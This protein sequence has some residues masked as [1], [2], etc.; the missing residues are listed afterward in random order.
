M[1]NDPQEEQVAGLLN[2]SP[3][4]LGDAFDGSN[5]DSANGNN[6]APTESPVMV[7][8]PET[9]QTSTTNDN[10]EEEKYDAGAVAGNGAYN[11][12][13]QIVVEDFV[14]PPPHIPLHAQPGT[15]DREKRLAAVE[16]KVAADMED[17]KVPSKV[18]YT[19]YD[20]DQPVP[21]KV[22][23][24]VKPDLNTVDQ[25]WK[26]NITI[27]D[28]QLREITHFD[29][30]KE[31]LWFPLEDYPDDYVDPF[32]EADDKKKDKGGKGGG[33]DDKKKKK[34]KKKKQAPPRKVFVALKVKRL[35][36]VDNIAETFR[37]RFHIYF[38]WLPTESDYKSYYKA[39]S[40]TDEK[41]P[42][43]LMDWEPKWYPHLE[44]Q[45]M[46]EQHTKEWELYPDEGNF[47]IQHFS[48]FAKN[49]GE[50]IPENQFDCE[51]AVFL[52][53]KLE[54]EMTF[55][56]ELELQSFP[57]DCQDLSCIIHERTT[58][59]VRC[60]FL[61]ELRKPSFA[62]VDP[63]YSVID[64]WD[65]ETA[66]IEF[67]DADPGASRSKSSYAMI[68][69]RLKMKRRWKV[70][71]ANIVFLMACISLLALTAF[72]LD[73]D[74]LGDRL[75]LLITLILTAVAFS[76]VV[77]DSLPNV[78]Y[79]TFMDKYILGNYGFLVGLM[80]ISAFMR[81]DWY[82][83]NWDLIIFWI[84]LSWL[85][86]YNVAFGIYGRILRRDEALKLAYS[87]DDVEK[88][89]NLSRPGLRFDYTKRLRAGINGRLLSFIGY[90]HATDHMSA[91]QKADIAKKQET[92]DILYKGATT[93]HGYD[94]SE[95]PLSPR[96]LDALAKK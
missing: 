59:G 71:F 34:K 6:G 5:D 19:V 20:K 84:A 72:S 50:E 35:S 23:N 14:T 41:N 9:T 37:M 40:L 2:L 1:A 15:E 92:L 45:N 57:F 70:F 17:M 63:R 54:C 91:E 8:M 60:V 46:I 83:E 27:G 11:T 61:P 58:G 86:V 64:E 68:V 51:K 80:I 47:R 3:N 7:S 56:E 42:Q 36:A 62:S 30:K 24:Q 55:A 81:Q 4:D 67:G 52:R 31:T 53:A 49:K 78:P 26:Y 66:I 28:V 18:L 13:T 32:D 85:F 75:N 39:K 43:L 65:L 90:T 73:K 22:H 48:D 33:D 94:A 76:Y 82:G 12:G 87:S 89:V 10:E 77:F 38:N 25:Q 95:I 79:L 88:E 44:F 69:L 16:E 96:A 74:D 21:K 29:G 93:R